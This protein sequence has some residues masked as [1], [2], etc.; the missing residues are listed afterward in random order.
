VHPAYVYS[1][2]PAPTAKEIKAMAA[3][4][5]EGRSLLLPLPAVGM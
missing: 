3:A 5:V 2:Y 1:A 4:N